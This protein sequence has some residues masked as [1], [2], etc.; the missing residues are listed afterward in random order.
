MRRSILTVL[1][2]LMIG[3][4]CGPKAPDVAPVD[5]ALNLSAK[6]ELIHFAPA[7]DMAAITSGMGLG[8]KTLNHRVSL[9]KIKPVTTKS[10][11]TLEAGMIGGNWST[12]ETAKDMPV[13]DYR[14]NLV[15][16]KHAMRFLE[17]DVPIWIDAPNWTVDRDVEVDLHAHGMEGFENY[18]VV[19]NGLTIN[20]D[21]PQVRMTYP[22]NYDPANG[23]TPSA[24]G[25]A[26]SQCI[27]DKKM[28][29]FDATIKLVFGQADRRNMNRAIPVSRTATVLHVVLIGMN[30][31]WVSNGAVSRTVDYPPPRLLLQPKHNE[32]ITVYR[33]IAVHKPSE[34]VSAIFP[35]VR[36]FF[37][38]F[39]RDEKT[40][41]YLRDIKFALEKSAEQNRQGLIMLDV[42]GYASNAGVLTYETLKNHFEIEFM[43]IGAPVEAKTGHVEQEFPVGT[44]TIPLTP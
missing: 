1:L 20:T 35:A 28:V 13:I 4:G 8:W 31:G 26:V 21:V 25:A 6:G 17:I 9:W 12:G 29:K 41:D 22:A 18:V 23:Y 42:T 14:Y 36:S 16:G 24:I 32:E 37:F 38:S 7:Q 30:G 15:S 44:T 5:S 27:A 40:G 39:Y 33:D 11:A 43:L 3:V 10:A 34:K 2:I 19:V